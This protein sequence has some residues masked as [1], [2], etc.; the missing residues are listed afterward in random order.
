MKQDIKQFTDRKAQI[1]VIAPHEAEKVKAYWNKENLPFTGIPDPDGRLGKLYG[2]EWKLIKLGRMPALFIIDQKGT[3]AFAQYANNMADIP[4]NG[5]LLQILEE[6][7]NR[8][9]RPQMEEDGRGK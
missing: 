9:D 5:T 2:Q 1:I 7:V 8:N 3:I 6:L 4:G